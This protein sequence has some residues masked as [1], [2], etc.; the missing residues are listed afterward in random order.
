MVLNRVLLISVSFHN[1]VGFCVCKI[2]HYWLTTGERRKVGFT[3][4]SALKS[5]LAG[6]SEPHVNTKVIRDVV[7]KKA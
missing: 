6:N 3:A 7:R 1:D 2:H 5:F 4:L